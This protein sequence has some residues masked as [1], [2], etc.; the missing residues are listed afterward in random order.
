MNYNE[1]APGIRR[2]IRRD[3][4][5]PLC[6][7]KISS[8]ENMEFLWFRNGRYKNYVFFHTE[9]LRRSQEAQNGEEIKEKEY[10][11]I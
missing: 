1:L 3:P 2:R 6:G 8:V 4:I 5:C 9:C 10:Q 11:K 7:Q